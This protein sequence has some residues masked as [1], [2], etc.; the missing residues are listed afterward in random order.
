V[1]DRGPHAVE[2]DAWLARAL[3]DRSSDGLVQQF[4]KTLHALWAR[5]QP[6]LGEVTLSAI[7]ERVLYNASERFTFFS[8]MTVESPK[9]IQIADLA[10]R[11]A[12]V[13]E[14]EQI[15][16]IR[17][18]LVELLTV[19]GNLTAEILTP[20]LHAELLRGAP[21]KKKSRRAKGT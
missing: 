8:T 11:I 1:G 13:P 12:H 19:L 7:A 14:A 4:G 17:F 16:G 9:G 21:L 15:A 20:E 3:S 6:K 18:L 2:V 10:D 5:T